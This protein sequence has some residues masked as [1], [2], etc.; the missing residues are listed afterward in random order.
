MDSGLI[1]LAIVVIL[2]VSFD[3]ING[4]HDTANA[5]ATV[6]ATPVLKQWQAIL[7]AG[8]LN[9]LGALTVTAVAASVGKG[10]LDP[11]EVTP[12]IVMT[13]GTWAFYRDLLAWSCGLPV[14][15]S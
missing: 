4:F 6:I 14:F 11:A 8:G 12:P 10:I 3:F 7:M 1:L 15:T 9:F 5:I 13:A 2:A